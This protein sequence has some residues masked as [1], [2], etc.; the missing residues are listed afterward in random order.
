MNDNL[1]KTNIDLPPEPPPE[2]PTK[3]AFNQ[4][5]PAGKTPTI[6]ATPSEAPP[7]GKKSG[8]TKAILISLAA[9][10]LLVSIPAAV[11]LVQQR[12]DI[13]EKAAIGNDGPGG[14]CD[15][16]DPFNSAEGCRDWEECAVDNGACETGKSCRL[17]AGECKGGGSVCQENWECCAGY[18]TGGTCESGGGGIPRSA[19]QVCEAEGGSKT[20]LCSADPNCGTNGGVCCQKGSTNYCCYGDSQDRQDGACY[21]GG[22]QS[23]ITCG[24]RTMTNNTNETKT[25]YR[26]VGSDNSCPFESPSGEKSIAPGQSLTASCEQ[27]EVPGA[28]GVCDDSACAPPGGEPTPTPTP[29]PSYSHNCGDVQVYD[30]SWNPITSLSAIQPGQTVRFTVWGETNNPSGITKGR[31]K[32]NDG[33]W[34]E[35][36][37]KKPSSNEFYIEYTIPLAGGTFSVDGEVYNSELGWK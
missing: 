17:K 11:F 35:T 12:Q 7:K 6:V 24:G 36:L 21:A 25:V 18:C 37:N 34:Q 27:L 4:T 22:G 5:P 32:V 8:K 30:T 31:I 13:R 10:L 19:L 26:F 15:P 29:P 14:C 9:F 20:D 1:P 3:T 2:M 28:C 33:A 23:E 16:S